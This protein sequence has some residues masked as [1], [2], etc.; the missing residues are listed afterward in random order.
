L[1]SC[2]AT[3]FFR[4]WSLLSICQPKTRNHP[5]ISAHNNSNHQP[6]AH[7]GSPQPAFTAAAGG[8]EQEATH[9]LAEVDELLARVLEKPEQLVDSG[10]TNGLPVDG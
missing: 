7:S 4:F 3:S 9:L 5:A 2:T 10:K 6:T 1:E 8:G